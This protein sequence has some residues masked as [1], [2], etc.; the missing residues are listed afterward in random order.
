MDEIGAIIPFSGTTIPD[1]YLICNGAAI[2]RTDY[3]D[4]FS[5]IGTT[6]G[7]CDGSTTFN[8]PNLTGL[9]TIGSDST[10]V[11]GAT[12]GEETHVLTATEIASHY[13]VVPQHGHAHTIVAK[14]PSLSHSITQPVE[15]YTCLNSTSA[16]CQSGSRNV[17]NGRTS[18]AMTKSTNLAVSNHTATACTMS[19]SV[20]QK[21]AYNS[22]STGGDGAHN[23][24]MPYITLTYIICAA[25]ELPAGDFMVFFN[26]ALP[27]G[28]SGAYICGKGR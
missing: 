16:D 4:L 7:V 24:M 1:R 8:L 26:G 17:Y 20:T 22:S 10:Y 13:H 5:V 27:V 2:S 21:D 9:T 19:G 28:P 3:A 12:G 14:T 18:T 11:L 6:Y 23:N 15:K 25:P